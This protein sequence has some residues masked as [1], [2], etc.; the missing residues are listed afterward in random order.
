M[1]PIQIHLVHLFN[2]YMVMCIL[3]NYPWLEDRGINNTQIPESPRPQICDDGII[4]VNSYPEEC[5]QDRLGHK[6][7]DGFE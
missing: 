2:P 5:S 4:N 3:Q 7:L 6:K 1:A